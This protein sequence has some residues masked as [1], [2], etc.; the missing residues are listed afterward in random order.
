MTSPVGA[1]PLAQATQADFSK[2]GSSSGIVHSTSSLQSLEAPASA[3]IFSW[4]YQKIA[5][6]LSSITSFFSW[7]YAKVFGSAAPVAPTPVK[8]PNAVPASTIQ[9][10][11]PVVAIPKTYSL[12][13]RIEVGKSE[14]KSLWVDACQV[15]LKHSRIAILV[16][17]NGLERIMIARMTKNNPLDFFNRNFEAFLRHERNNQVAGGV[18]KFRA[19]VVRKEGEGSF[20]DLML[21]RSFDFSRSVSARSSFKNSG[22]A[23]VV[24]RQIQSLTQ[25]PRKQKELSQFFIIEKTPSKESRKPR[26]PHSAEIATQN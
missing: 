19:L 14:L 11:K 5:S 26:E 8:P 12:A 20:E 23:Q 17:Y 22:N 21:E 7:C 3:G 4:A 1:R 15:E 9:E 13:E 24:E 18:L 2:T 16:N 25:T 10:S 6:L